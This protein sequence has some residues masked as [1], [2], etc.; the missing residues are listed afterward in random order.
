MLKDCQCIETLLIDLLHRLF[1]SL[2]YTKTWAYLGMRHRRQLPPHSYCWWCTPSVHINNSCVIGKEEYFRKMNQTPSTLDIS[3]T[4]E[5]FQ[6]NDTNAHHQWSRNHF[7]IFAITFANRFDDFLPLLSPPDVQSIVLNNSSVL[8][9]R[10]HPFS[11]V[12]KAIWHLSLHAQG[13]T[14]NNCCRGG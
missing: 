13:Y 9:K 10:F 3:E 8:K 12:T 2:A 7:W 1:R 11:Y 5:R 6:Q 14:S 4:V